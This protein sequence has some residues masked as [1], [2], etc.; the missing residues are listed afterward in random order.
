MTHSQGTGSG[1]LFGAFSAWSN[2][3][4]RRVGF[5]AK[6]VVPHFWD[7]KFNL[8]FLRFLPLALRT[9]DRDGKVVWD[10]ESTYCSIKQGLRCKTLI[11]TCTREDVEKSTPEHN[12]V[13]TASLEKLDEQS[14]SVIGAAE[15]D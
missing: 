6:R 15:V 11:F 8:G 9:A 2:A 12:D 13:V 7:E 3:S 14:A 1:R 10:C 5:S 4:S